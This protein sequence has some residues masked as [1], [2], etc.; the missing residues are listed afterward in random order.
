MKRLEIVLPVCLA[1]A[2]I[3]PAGCSDE[4]PAPD[5]AT[6]TAPGPNAKTVNDLTLDL[7]KGVTMKLALIRAGEFLIGSPKTETGRFDDEGPQ[8]RVTIG[9]PFHMGVCEVTQ[10]QWRAVM[11]SA[12]WDGGEWAKSDD[13]HAASYITWELANKFCITLSK[14]TNRIITLPSEAQ[15][16]YA[17]RANSTTTYS[18]GD[19][20]SKLRRYA[21]CKANAWDKNEMYAHL[22]GRKLPN[23]WGLHDMHG[24]VWEWCSDWYA[25]KNATATTERVFRGGSWFST[26]QLCRAAFRDWS[27]ADPRSRFYGL[28]VVDMGPAAAPAYDL[29][30]RKTSGPDFMNVIKVD[31]KITDVL[32]ATP[33]GAENAAEHYAR[34]VKLCFANWDALYDAAATLANGDATQHAGALKTL[35][36]IRRHIGKG[37]KQAGMNYLEKHASGKLKVSLRQEDTDRLGRTVD[38][39]SL[40]GDYYIK[41]KRLKDADAI[42]RDMFAAG[43]HMINERSSIHMTRYGVDVQILA[44]K[45]IATSIDGDLD[46][47]AKDNR[48]APL[49]DSLVALNEFRSSCQDKALIFQE[50]R[51]DAGNIWNIAENDKD[52]AW[53]VQAILAMGLIKFTHTSK[54]NAEHNNAMIEQFLTSSDPLEKAAAQ[55]AKAYTE[56]DFNTAGTT[57]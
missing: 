35:Q 40:L 21:W 57:W 33:S 2:L 48:M 45:G 43:W 24:N 9:K 36:E 15:W 54:A 53:R 39:L 56:N 47:N 23:A 19:D 52:R 50:A 5:V 34:A 1:L 18:Y 17:C 51:F 4:E 32:N 10:A 37:A 27:A 14:Q 26:A 38:V 25:P 42:Y 7:G 12:P 11:G 49:R 28:R 6:T 16:E 29:P 30:T 46:K 13:N 22:V 3:S 44:L 31:A 20:T 55:A 8:R 41:N